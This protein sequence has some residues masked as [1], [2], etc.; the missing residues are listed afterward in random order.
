MKTWQ[1]G[2][3]TSWNKSLAY[4]IGQCRCNSSHVTTGLSSESPFSEWLFAFFCYPL[5]IGPSNV[6][7]GISENQDYSPNI[8]N[9]L[10]FKHHE[11]KSSNQQKNQT[12]A[13]DISLVHHYHHLSIHCSLQESTWISQIPTQKQ[14]P[15]Q[16]RAL[17]PAPAGTSKRWVVTLFR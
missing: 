13:M 2:C 10:L 12:T 15:V 9:M 11:T 1:D 7:K 5:T 3:T 14:S 4:T 8:N 6:C 17:P 16:R